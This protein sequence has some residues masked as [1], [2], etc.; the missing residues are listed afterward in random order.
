M[1]V[2]NV[3]GRLFLLHIRCQWPDVIFSV[4]SVFY[5]PQTIVV[6][7]HSIWSTIN[8]NQLFTSCSCSILQLLFCLFFCAVRCRDC[9]DSPC[10]CG[11]IFIIVCIIKRWLYILILW[12]LF[13]HRH[14]SLS[15]AF[16]LEWYGAWRWVL[17]T[18]L[19]VSFQSIFQLYITG[20]RM[21]NYRK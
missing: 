5:F 2:L 11:W 6:Q 21:L 7:K 8:C 17:L 4:F 16:D 9:F 20:S 3:T 1:K 18:W 19:Q 13:G 15:A 10:A 12:H 14:P